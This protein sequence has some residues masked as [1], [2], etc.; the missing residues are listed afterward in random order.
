MTFEQL[1]CFIASVEE[2]T[3]LDAA[4]SLHISQSSLS[5]QIMKLE[6][7]LEVELWDRKKRK[8]VLTK[9]GLLFYQ[10]ARILIKQY[11]DAKNKLNRYRSQAQYTLSIGTLPILS[12]YQLTP[13]FTHFRETHPRLH[14]S[15]HEVEEEDLM[16]GFDR[17]AYD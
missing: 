1:Q 10:D 7:E 14:L 2:H 12:Q 3:F 15:L 6:Q 17:G 5:K 8:A 11:T 4:E 16:E 9:A 13:V